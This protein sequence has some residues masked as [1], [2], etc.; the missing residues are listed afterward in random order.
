VS[1]RLS[2]ISADRRLE[3]RSEQRV[4]A[5]IV[6]EEGFTLAA[7]LLNMSASG[8]KIRCPMSLDSGDTLHVRILGGG[9][10][11]ARVAWHRGELHGCKFAQHINIDRQRRLG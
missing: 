3:N 7:E 6:T 11:V 8:F 9:E 5:E 1:K 10:Y 2:V 4:K